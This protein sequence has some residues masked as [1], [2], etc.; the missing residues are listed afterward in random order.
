METVELFNPQMEARAGP[1]TFHSGVA[2]E[3][4]SSVSSYF[5]WAKI[6]FTEEYQPEVEIQLNRRDPAAIALGYDGVMDDVFTGYVAKRY[7]AADRA[8]EILL[9]DEALL[10]KDTTIN[11]TFLD[12]TPQ[13]AIAYVLGKAGITRTKLSAKQYP[14][15]RRTPIRQMD[16]IQAINAID[17]AWNIS[18][19]F[20]FSGGVFYWGTEPEQTRLYTFEYGVNIITLE[21]VGGLWVLETASAPFVRHSHKI[22]IIHPK[23]TGE[24]KVLEVITKTN[25]DGFIRT[26]MYFQGGQGDA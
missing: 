9:H 17:A 2:V 1:Y 10:L 26:R 12:A 18:T 22:N 4:C 5:D 8:D 20:F 16:A 3:L 15:R 13:E 14:R 25:E 24:V 6:R 23:I 19:R 11:D 21:R 7:N